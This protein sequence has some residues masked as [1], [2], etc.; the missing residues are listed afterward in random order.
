MTVKNT[1]KAILT[2]YDAHYVLSEENICARNVRLLESTICI[3]GTDHTIPLS[4]KNWMQTGK[5][6]AP[7]GRWQKC[8]SLCSQLRL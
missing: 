2:S 6:V 7:L 5:E 3:E 4:T 8:H 1:N